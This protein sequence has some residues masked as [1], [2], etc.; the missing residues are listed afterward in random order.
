VN[1]GW[2]LRIGARAWS[3][4]AGG[5]ML[6]SFFEWCQERMAAS[7]STSMSLSSTMQYSVGL[8]QAPERDDRVNARGCEGYK[9]AQV[10]ETSLADWP[11]LL[12]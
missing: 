5:S 6:A 10:A 2:V 12:K 1:E 3:W 8:V 4:R 11:L 7:L 9:H